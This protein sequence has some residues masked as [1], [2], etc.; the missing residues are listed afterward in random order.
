MNIKNKNILILGSTGFL[1]KN[2]CIKL[3]EKGIKFFTLTKKNCNLLNY[4]VSKKKISKIKPDII[5]NCAGKVGGI[6]YNIK[7]PSEIF[8]NNIT[9][10]LNVLKISSTLKIKKLVNIGSSCCY[11]SDLKNKL[12][13]KDLFKGVLHPTVEAYGFWK[14]TSIIGA[15]A[16]FSEKKLNTINVIFPSMYGPYDKFDPENSHVVSSLITKFYKAIKEKKNSITLWGTGE[17]IREFIHVDDAVDILLKI[18]AKYN[19]IKPINAGI[20]KGY[21][22]KKIAAMISKIYNFKGKILWD[23]SKPNGQK[24]KIL[25]NSLLKKTIKWK[26]N[27][28]IQD[29]LLNTIE[30]FKKNKAMN[31]Q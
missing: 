25:N 10:L 24:Q 18:T 20:S 8:Y 26:P 30:W 1:G 6:K 27:V 2:L 7:K 22:I 9:I 16:F 12:N 23:A 21:K 29:G 4:E 31:V 3:K 13:E 14:L 15:K 11:P 17:P 28:K 5:F 19:S